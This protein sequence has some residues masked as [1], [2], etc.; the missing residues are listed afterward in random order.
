M[1]P[2]LSSSCNR[3]K[4]PPQERSLRV[5]T[6]RGIRGMCTLC[7][8]QKVVDG[9]KPVG[10]VG[11]TDLRK[12]ENASFQGSNAGEISLKRQAFSAQGSR[13][14][15]HPALNPNRKTS[16]GDDETQ[17]KNACW[18]NHLLGSHREEYKQPLRRRK[19]RIHF[20]CRGEQQTS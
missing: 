12:I 19:T 10:R 5:Y 4:T 17:S 11:T 15:C 20:K 3:K 14:D 6:L 13:H 9:R 16:S 2:G 7:K 8:V 18:T 1:E